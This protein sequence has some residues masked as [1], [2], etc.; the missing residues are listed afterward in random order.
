MEGKI[1]LEQTQINAS[2]NCPVTLGLFTL[3][4]NELCV[5]PTPGGP[6]PATH[7]G[8]TSSLRLALGPRCCVSDCLLVLSSFS[9]FVYDPPRPLSPT[10]L[11][12]SACLQTAHSQKNPYFIKRIQPIE[13]HILKP[14]T[15]P[16]YL[17]PHPHFPS[18]RCRRKER[19]PSSQSHP[20]PLCHPEGS[21]TISG[22]L[23]GSVWRSGPLLISAQGPGMEPLLGSRLR[24]ESASGLSLHFPSPCSPSLSKK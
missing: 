20:F 13:H 16:S 4:C 8:T 3:Y 11:K 22:R 10:Y 12:T 2:V 19:C 14:S 24:E 5:S 1:Q 23:C 9:S 18:Y 21:K 15:L 17:L 7:A 6:N